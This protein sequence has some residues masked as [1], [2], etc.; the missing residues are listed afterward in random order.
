MV[1]DRAISAAGADP[2]GD[3]HRDLLTDMQ[4][5]VDEVYVDPALIEYAVRLASATRDPAA[6]GLGD[7]ARYISFGASPRASI[8]LILAARA[9]AFVRGRDYALPP[10]VTD[11]AARRAAPPPGPVVR[12]DVA[13]RSAPTR[14]CGG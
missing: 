5:R 8:S 12:G 9:L 7:L 10:D 14:S 6:V 3:R 2:A 13:T 4:R 11:L 1:V